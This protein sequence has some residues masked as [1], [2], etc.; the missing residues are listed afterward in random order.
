M[1][2]PPGLGTASGQRRALP[3]VRARQRAG[4]PFGSSGGAVAGLALVTAHPVRLRT[5]AAHEP[6][7]VELLPGSAQVR[8]QIADIY[9]T[10]RSGGAGKAMGKFIVH[11]AWVMDPAGKRTHR[12]GILLRSSGPGR[13]PPPLCSSST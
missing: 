11:A 6:P 9:H 12:A 3:V 5:L 4:H 8:A 10:C 7:P 1:R 13:A 2:E